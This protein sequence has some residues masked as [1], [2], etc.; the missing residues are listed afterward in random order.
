MVED[1][2]DQGGRPD[3]S[4]Q[5]DPTDPVAGAA[6]DGRLRR[7]RPLG[8][9]PPHR[10]PSS[11][12]PWSSPRPP[13]FLPAMR[14]TD[15][16]APAGGHSAD[17]AQVRPA[18]FAPVF[19][20]RGRPTPSLCP[21]GPR[22]RPIAPVRTTGSGPSPARSAAERPALVPDA[23]AAAGGRRRLRLRTR[24]LG[25]LFHCDGCFVDGG[26]AR[27]RLRRR[28]RRLRRL[29]LRHGGCCGDGNRLLRL[30]AST[31]CGGPRATTCRR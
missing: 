5:D 11:A 12:D 21:P 27:L 2:P 24:L 18:S 28:L 8:L 20:G 16:V 10:P 30:R 6:R 25:W 1:R 29:R 31:C 26:C 14:R 3:E 13:A 17:H 7:R 19:R 15:G 23:G 9:R 4:L 22:R